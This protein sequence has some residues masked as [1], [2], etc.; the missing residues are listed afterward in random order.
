MSTIWLAMIGVGILTFLTRLSFIALL[1]RWQA[2]LIVQ[3]ALRF[4]PIAVL[5]AIVIPELVLKDAIINLHPDNPRLLAGLVAILVAWK[6]KNVTITIV[7]GMT[8]LWLL[9]IIFQ[10]VP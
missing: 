6:T 4:V 7:A 10:L 5:T 1:E 9:Q 3:R 8:V 2:P